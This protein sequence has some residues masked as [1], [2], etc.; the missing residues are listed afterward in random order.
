MDHVVINSYFIEMF[1]YFDSKKYDLKIVSVK[2]HI[3]FKYKMSI[4]EWIKQFN[5]TEI[6]EQ[7]C[8]I[9]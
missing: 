9:C 1:K 2:E 4:D 6:N 3:Q 8:I 5:E 7:S